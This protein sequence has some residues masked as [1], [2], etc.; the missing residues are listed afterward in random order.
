MISYYL[1]NMGCPKNEVDGQHLE[2]I[3]ADEG[4]ISLPEPQDADMI[5]VNTCGFI[6]DACKESIHAILEAIE[7]KKKRG[8]TIITV[9]CLPQRYGKKFIDSLPELDVI[10]GVGIE[11]GFRSVLKKYKNKNLK[12]PY[13]QISPPFAYG[14]YASHLREVKGNHFQY[15]KIAEGCTNQCAYC[16][17]PLIRGPLRSRPMEDILKEGE[18]LVAKG[19]QELILIAQDTTS[20][21][22][23]LYGKPMLYKLLKETAQ[24]PVKWVRLM[25]A[26]PYNITTDVLQLISDKDNICNYLDMPI[27]HASHK[28]LKKMRRN[29]SSLDI[30]E[31]ILTINKNFPDIALRTT[32]M[33]GFPGE[34]E[35]NFS[36]LEKL[37]R[38][39]RF[40]HIGIFKYSQEEGTDAANLCDQ[41]PDNIKEQRYNR[42][43]NMQNE[44]SREKLQNLVGEK[45]E[46]LIDNIEENTLLGRTQWDAPE[47]DNLVYIE[48]DEKRT[49][50]PGQFVK[51]KIL[52]GFEHE[53]VGEILHEP[54]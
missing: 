17:I 42:L 54:T 47:I 33:V 5:I 31:L 51:V 45:I 30:E 10:M 32:L 50:K 53:L 28:I 49:A 29:E 26:Q 52:M 35:D 7:Y 20:Y 23:D 25:Y 39:V 13:V 24:L 48:S 43:I 6:E 2:G 12:T 34:T 16:T 11:K 18:E 8:T 44:I 37:I 40:T 21:G 4:F 15:L 41:V 19:A 9:G 27:Q 38:K 22:L 46:V 14:E 1:V 36:L 3:L